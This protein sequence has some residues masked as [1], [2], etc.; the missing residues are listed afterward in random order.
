MLRFDTVANGHLQTFYFSPVYEIIWLWLGL[1]CTVQYHTHS[2]R[3]PGISYDFIVPA[4]NI[5]IIFI[6]FS[7]YIRFKDSGKKPLCLSLVRDCGPRWRMPCGWVAPSGQTCRHPPKHCSTFSR[8]RVAVA[9]GPKFR[10]TNSKSRAL[11]V[12]LFFK[13]F[14]IGLCIVAYKHVIMSHIIS[15]CWGHAQLWNLIT[16]LTKIFFYFGPPRT[17]LFR[18]KI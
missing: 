13:V 16:T 1:N 17:L 8:H 7:R 14:K 11:A 4:V 2:P 3:L 10:P 18:N 12:G 6:Q 15:K 5:V 9:N